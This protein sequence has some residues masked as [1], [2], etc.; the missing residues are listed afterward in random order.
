M[1]TITKILDGIGRGD[2]RAV[3]RLFAVVYDELRQMAAAQMGHEQPGHTLE[4]TA[5]DHEAYMRLVGD[6]PFENR[7]HFFA[8]CAEA[9]RRILVEQA[10]RKN[11]LRRG[12]DRERVALPDDLAAP[13]R[14]DEDLLAVH[15]A[16]DLFARED[17]TTAE[18]VKLHYFAGMTI[19]QA[20]ELLDLSP[21]TA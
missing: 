11:A 9:M 19:E 15:E 18:L 20:A 2:P 5:L 3:E 12:G 4:P 6:H 14:D 1:N 10:R 17:P 16:L 21:R 7:R 8:A 13:D